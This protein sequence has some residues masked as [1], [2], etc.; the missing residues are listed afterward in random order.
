MLRHRRRLLRIAA[1][2]S[3]LGLIC[4]LLAVSLAGG[5]PRPQQP[6]APPADQQTPP[7]RSGNDNQS[8]AGRPVP[9]PPIS[10]DALDDGAG[11]NAGGGRSSPDAGLP[12]GDDRRKPPS[13]DRRESISIIIVAPRIDRE[14]ARNEPVEVL[15]RAAGDVESVELLIRPDDADEFIAVRAGLNAEGRVEFAARDPG[16]YQLAIRARNAQSEK[17][18]VA[19]GR[20]TVVGDM[21]IVVDQPA[22]E[23]IVRPAGRVPLSYSVVTLA[24][25]VEAQI[26]LDAD[27]LTDGDEIWNSASRLKSFEGKLDTAGLQLGMTYSVFVQATDSVGQVSS[28]FYAPG[29]FRLVAAPTLSVTAPTGDDMISAGTPV[30]IAFRATDSENAST[31]SVFVDTDRMLNG[32][33]RVI[34]ANLPLA[35]TEYVVDTAWF[36]PGSYSFGAYVVDSHS[37]DVVAVAYAPGTRTVPGIRIDAPAADEQRKPPQ[38]VAM[39]WTASYPPSAFSEH[40]VVVAADN[41]GD[42]QP[43]G[44]V[45]V[46]QTGFKPGGN[47]YDVSTVGLSGRYLLGVRLT[48]NQEHTI[49]RWARGT[50][51]VANN[52][53]TIEIQR[54]AARIAARPGTPDAIVEMRFKVSDS[55]NLLRKPDGIAIVAARDDNR[56]GIP[57]G[58]PVYE[59]SDPRLRLGNNVFPF[60][61]SALADAGLIDDEMHDGFGEF[62]LGV[63]AVDDA[64]QTAVAFAPGGLH[65]DRVVPKIELTRP[66]DDLVVDRMGEL[67]IK[68][69]TA[70]TSPTTVS[71]LLDRDAVPDNTFDGH[72]LVPPTPFAANEA[73]DF[74]F[75]LAAIPPG[76]YYYYLRIADGVSPAIEHYW[77]PNVEDPDELRTIWVRDRLIGLVRVADFEDSDQGAILCGFNFNDLAGSSMTSVPDLDDDGDDEFVIVSRFGKPFIINNDAGVGFGEAYLIYGGGGNNRNE[78]PKRLRGAQTLNAVGRGAISGLAMPGMRIPLESTWTEGISDVVVVDDMDG[79]DLP[80]LV[81]SFPRVESINLGTLDTRIQHPELLPDIPGMGNLEYDA[82]YGDDPESLEWHLNEAQFTRGGIVIV[83]SHNTNMTNENVRNR[84]FDRLIDLHEIGQM[85]AGFEGAM[86]PPEFLP[87][88]YGIEPLDFDVDGDGTIDEGSAEGCWDCDERVGDCGDNRQNPA[89][90][91]YQSWRVLWDVV[92]KSQPPGGFHMPWSS[93]NADP[94]LANPIPFLI[95]PDLLSPSNPPP[96]G[97]C[98]DLDED[99]TP[100]G[101]AWVNAWQST[102]CPAPFPCT[103]LT[104]LDSWK[105]GEVSVWTGF[106]NPGAIRDFNVGA[107]VLGQAVDDRFGTAVGS[108]GTWLYIS[109]PRHTAERRDVPLMP[110]DRRVE[111]GVVYQYRVDT[112]SRDGEPT[113]SQLW[114]EPGLTDCDFDGVRETPIVWPLV[115]YDIPCRTDVTMPVPHQ[116]IIETI[117]STRGDPPGGKNYDYPSD[118]PTGYAAGEGGPPAPAAIGCYPAPVGTAGYYMDRTPQIVG[119]HAAARISFVRGLGDINDDGIRDFAVGSDTVRADF[120]DPDSS[121][122]GAIFIVFSRSTGLEGDYLLERLALSPRDRRRL[123]GVLLKGEPDT[124]IA[125]VFDTAGDFNGDGIADVLVGSERSDRDTGQAIVI[126][127]SRTLLSPEGGF[128]LDGIVDVGRA[129]RF[130]GVRPGDLAGA[131]VAGAGDVDADGLGD[132]LIAA[133]N[134][135][136]SFEQSGK[137]PPDPPAT[138]PGV[139]YLIY[140]SGR[141]TAGVFDLAKV[142]TPALPGAVF[143]GR[144]AGDFVGGGQL[145]IVVNPDGKPTTIYS[146]GV[147]A[148]GDIDGDGRDDYA[149]SAILADPFGKTNAGEVYIIYGRG[150][151]P[152]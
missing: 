127:G 70:D 12:P 104:C 118:C 105:V 55:E 76:L 39:R 27:P 134:A 93:V 7:R 150:D 47:R 87:Y 28:R 92:F 125:H 26:F 147:A 11:V 20:V 65:L 16:V 95:D 66:A 130:V 78:E 106:Y 117:G 116:Y 40:A 60:D 52:A 113:R 18:A 19:P 1:H 148:L 112:R 144:A 37:Q 142:G 71:L 90:T 64:G 75:D 101:C 49:T 54:P 88:I 121:L 67:T 83:S 15:Y 42:R 120:G 151:R 98:V 43:D 108:D 137:R 89:E 32:D 21:R 123:N 5:C 58:D 138:G 135:F 91:P 140:G 57:D 17:T 80:E 41:D 102:F 96:G 74:V 152:E 84:K 100:D 3:A 9:P 107:R 69:T 114:L 4:S 131:G 73:R 139:V 6:A 109:A 77:P 86:S 48:D 141:H 51:I 85:F 62:L 23:L 99:G 126:F 56:D 24:R 34:V 22:G 94:P 63:R 44:D 82:F 149:L 33:E 53:P 146:R 145:E 68:L 50:L 61:A 119:P 132:I 128:T 36:E 8:V 79:D 10:D 97:I 136:P 29:R 2:R 13:D 59:L 111:S 122:V 38:T 30:T 129:M 35:Q 110:E 31:V 115:D 46:V 143:V 14:V 103:V 81:F 45:R 133:P 25:S 72:V 124:P